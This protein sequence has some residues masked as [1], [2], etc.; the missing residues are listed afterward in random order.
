[1]EREK[2]FKLE[3]KEIF[4]RSCEGEGLSQETK[5]GLSRVFTESELKE[6]FLKIG[7]ANEYLFNIIKV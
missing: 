6:F 5:E 3:I 7:T 1:M 4:K 2:K